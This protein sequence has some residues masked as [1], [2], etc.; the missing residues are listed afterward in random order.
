[1]LKPPSDFD[2]AVVN[3][4]RHNVQELTQIVIPQ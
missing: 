3:G 1:M 4:A 2:P